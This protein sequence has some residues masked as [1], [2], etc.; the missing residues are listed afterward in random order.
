MFEFEP[1][2]I[3]WTTVSFA[4]L[5]ILMYRL[6]LPPIIAVL[7]E[8]EKTITDALSAAEEGRK[9]SDELLAAYKQKLSEGSATAQKIID[10]AKFEGEKLKREI[11]ETGRKNAD[12]LMVRAQEDLKREKE[13]LV[14]EIKSETADLIIAAAGKLLRKN[15]GKAQNIE[16]IEETLK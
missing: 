1:G 10:Q 15:I 11:V 8:R 7:R 13:K 12:L 5:V 4:I 3:I 9:K 16:I 2:L 6:A 14:S